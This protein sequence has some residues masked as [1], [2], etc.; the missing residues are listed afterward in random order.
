MIGEIVSH[1][2]IVEKLGEGGMGSVY[3]AED[4]HLGRRVAIKFPHGATTDEQRYRARFLR[5]ARAVSGLSHPN[6]ATLYDYGETVEGHPFIVMELVKGVTLSQQ[7][8]GGQLTI[9]R[10]VEIIRDVAEA[11]DEAHHQGI[12]HRDVKPSN[13]I[14][15]ER[16]QVKVLDFGLVKHMAEEHSDSVDHEA[17]TLLTAHTQ[18]GMVIGT[19][20]YLSPEQARGLP[21][22]ARSDLFALGA[23]L[24]ECITGKPAFSG[25]NVVEIAAHVILGDPQQPTEVNPN[26]PPELQRITLKALA[27]KPDARYQTAAEFIA[28]LD[29]VRDSLKDLDHAPT[30]QVPRAHATSRIS[31]LATF[32]DIFQR[33]RLPIGTVLLVLLGLGLAVW[34]LLYWLKPSA[35]VPRAEAQQWYEAGT[36]AL[37]RRR[38]F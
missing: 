22:D 19:P 25:A 8:A 12:I 35:H 28:D 5:E 15:T 24:Y 3:A 38:I 18:S 20:L 9:L 26:I 11:L 6:I 1:Y 27:K 17:R 33:P 4:T 34:G 23:V 29:A 37:A 2:R 31:A 13:V 36:S 21:V 14:V 10:A 30:M 7:L 32:S 16:G